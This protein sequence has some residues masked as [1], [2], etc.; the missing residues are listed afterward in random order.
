MSPTIPEKKVWISQSNPE[1]YDSF[2]EL[3]DDV[4]KESTWTVTKISTRN[5]F[6][7]YRN[8]MGLREK[9]GDLCYF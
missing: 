5:F 8:I 6:G 3:K 7:G 1:R 2:N 4:V 9:C